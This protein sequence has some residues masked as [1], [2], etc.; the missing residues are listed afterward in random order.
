MKKPYEKPTIQQIELRPEERL[1][2]CGWVGYNQSRV[3]PTCYK[4]QGKS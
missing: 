1:A 4:G 2:G 3:R